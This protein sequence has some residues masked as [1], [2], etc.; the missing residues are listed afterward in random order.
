MT[1]KFLN[2]ILA[3][4]KYIRKKTRPWRRRRRELESRLLQVEKI[5]RSMVNLK[6]WDLSQRILSEPRYMEEKRLLRSGFKVHSQ[7]EEDGILHEIFSRIGTT[8]K[9]FI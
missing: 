8:T 9:T 1:K 4:F 7:N 5:T 2:N 6:A 3:L